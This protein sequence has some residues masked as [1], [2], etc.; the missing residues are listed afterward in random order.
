MIFHYLYD[1][2]VDFLGYYS[3]SMYKFEFMDQI[4]PMDF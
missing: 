2:I 3:K 4:G 1:K